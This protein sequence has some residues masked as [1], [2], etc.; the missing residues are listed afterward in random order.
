MPVL[1]LNQAK[2]ASEQPM[3]C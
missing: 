1:L 2:I 3:F